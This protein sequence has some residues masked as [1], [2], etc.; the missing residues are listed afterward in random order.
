MRP[1]IRLAILEA[2]TPLDQTRVQYGGYGGVFKALLRAGAE[3]IGDP[4]IIDSESGLEISMWH[5]ENEPDKYPKIEEI[6]AILIT[7]SRHNSFDDTP[8]IKTLVDYT[9]KVLAQD[10]VR[11]IGVCFGHQIIGRAM[12]VKVGRNDDGWEVSVS[13]VNL[14]TKGQEIFQQ[15]TLSLHQMHRDIVFYYPQGVEQLG[16]SPVCKVQGMYGKKRL[17]TVQGHPEFNTTIM[18]EILNKRYDLGI[19]DDFMFETAMSRVK[20]H[21]D[22]VVVA[23]AFLRFLLD[24]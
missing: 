19:F 17:I 7:G 15:D 2:D 18:T 23:K 16:S 6:D 1:P 4:D 13:R 11:L 21:H 22:G 12:G 3:D 14:T 24:E 5:V 9:A 8:W 10:H 20:L